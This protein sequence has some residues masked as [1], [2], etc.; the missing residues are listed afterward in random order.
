[1][2]P[3]YT[4]PADTICS[5]NQEFTACKHASL[6]LLLFADGFPLNSNF[7][8]DN[9][10]IAVSFEYIYVGIHKSCT[11]LFNTSLIF[12]LLIIA[13]VLGACTGKLRLSR[14]HTVKEYEMSGEPYSQKSGWIIHS[15]ER[16]FQVM[17][18]K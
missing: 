7:Y 8:S 11:K 12:L 18:F 2:F 16:I 5:E 6:N 10:T 9:Q 15:N 13:V 17:I 1:M 3:I 14:N 4:H